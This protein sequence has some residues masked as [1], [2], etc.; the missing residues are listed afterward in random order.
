M[1]DKSGKCIEGPPQ[2]G[3]VSM[4]RIDYQRVSIRNDR[5]DSSPRAGTKPVKTTSFNL[6]LESKINTPEK[7]SGLSFMNDRQSDLNKPFS[8]RLNFKRPVD[9]IIKSGSAGQ[10]MGE[11]LESGPASVRVSHQN[12]FDFASPRS[13]QNPSQSIMKPQDKGKSSHVVKTDE[14]NRILSYK[15]SEVQFLLNGV[16]SSSAF[17]GARRLMSRHMKN[18]TKE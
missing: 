12:K 1:T 9:F 5:K 10:H 15:D 17:K 13:S 3:S 16:S 6:D 2:I 4:S 14:S 18:R 8:A 7:P 11:L